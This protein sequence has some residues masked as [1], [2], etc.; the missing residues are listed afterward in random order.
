MSILV[1]VDITAASPIY[2]P[3]TTQTILRHFFLTEKPFNKE[4][5]LHAKYMLRVGTS[6]LRHSRGGDYFPSAMCS[7]DP[8]CV[9]YTGLRIL[10]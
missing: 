1:H 5:I 4:G 3:I 9:Y 6:Q 2:L 8:G 10:I 7:T